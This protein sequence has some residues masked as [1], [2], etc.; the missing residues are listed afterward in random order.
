M[1]TSKT[2]DVRVND[3]F[4]A[5]LERPALQW[6]CKHMPAWMT[7]DILTVFGFIG[8]A[9]M[10]AAYWL[11][12]VNK[13]F[14]WIVDFGL[15]IN[16]FGDSLDG[17]LARY[18]GIERFKYGYFVDH[19]V[20]ITTQTIVLLGLGASPFVH[21]NYALLALVGY[22]QLGILTYINTAVSGV[23]KISYGKIGPT[24]VRVFLVALNALFYFASNPTIQIGRVSILSF[25]AIVLLVAAAFFLYF[26]GFS[27]LRMMQLGVQDPPKGNPLQSQ[28]YRSDISR[29][30]V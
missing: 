4:L 2:A 20:D 13:N 10:A 15:V 18:R 12:D 7:P 16:W 21:F 14:L 8:G 6:L 19:T 3:T 17:S 5:P 11:C 24:E 1:E 22:L 30:V 27:L 25:D 26:L 9:I 28:S 29:E 23:Y